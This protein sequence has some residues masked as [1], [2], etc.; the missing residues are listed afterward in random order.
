MK[1]N[2][3]RKLIP[4]V[5]NM[6]SKKVK[7]EIL[8][9]KKDGSFTVKMVHGARILNVEKNSLGEYF[10]K[11]YP[12]LDMSE[13]HN[14]AVRNSKYA[15]FLTPTCIEIMNLPYFGW[16]ATEYIEAH[17]LGNFMNTEDTIGVFLL[18]ALNE[19]EIITLLVLTV[20]AHREQ[21]VERTKFDHAWKYAEK[22]AKD[23]CM[24]STFE[25]G[26]FPEPFS[27]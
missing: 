27:L 4:I 8:N 10:I 2:E 25:D 21:F 23:E 9:N 24:P 7:L 13:N 22:K 17:N 11:F 3:I 6:F 26:C 12:F 18:D 15:T 5:N 14:W 16:Q 1:P 20:L 19:R